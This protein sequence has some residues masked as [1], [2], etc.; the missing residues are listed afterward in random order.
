MDSGGAPRQEEEEADEL[1][2]AGLT[3]EEESSSGGPQAVRD[4]AVAGEQ[5]QISL[6]EPPAASGRK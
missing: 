3:G 5:F 2:A 4:V 1:T 6:V